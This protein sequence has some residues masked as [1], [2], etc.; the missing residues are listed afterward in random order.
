MQRFLDQLPYTLLI[1]AALLLGLAPFIP[2]PHLVEKFQM[3]LS[4]QLTRPIDQFDL[5]WHALPFALLLLKAAL[6]LRRKL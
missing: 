6:D 4:G 3:L 5:L 1:P 2:Q